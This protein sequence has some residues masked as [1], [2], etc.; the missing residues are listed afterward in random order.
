MLSDELL[1]RPVHI[2]PRRLCH[3][4]LFVS[5]LEASIAFYE[6]A[7]GLSLVSREPPINA[8]F[9][10]NG[11]THHDLGMLE[12]TREPVVGEAGHGILPGGAAADTGLYHLGWEMQNEFELV[13]AHARALA[14]GMR[15]NRTSCHRASNSVYVSD[16]D[17]MIHEFYADVVRDWRNAGPPKSGRWEPDLRTASL[18]SCFEDD[19][20]IAGAP[21][22]PL[23]PLRFSHAVLAVRDLDRQRRYFA[24]LAGLRELGHAR[25]NRFA[26]FATAANR[27][28]YALALVD[29]ALAQGQARRGLHHFAMEVAGEAE[30]DG[31]AG[32]LR[33][34]GVQVEREFD[35][36]HK[37]SLLLRDPDGVA[38]E[39]VHARTRRIDY[40]ALPLDADLG[41]LL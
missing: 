27:Y 1:D 14:L 39:I 8:A 25:Q 6:G 2:G 5:D 32:R 30:L 9:F 20:Q 23:A 28:P 16:A 33:A 40:D 4:N 15:V 11:S 18:E 10:S 26:V 13:K 22:A 24:N 29:A 35:L 17:G 31:A 12:V 21:G 41:Y 34:R 3:V 38:V 19:P 37:R 7:C 36:P